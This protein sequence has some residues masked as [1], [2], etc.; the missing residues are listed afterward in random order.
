[1]PLNKL[2][3]GDGINADIDETSNSDNAAAALVN[4]YRDRSG[5][6][7]TIIG[8]E[9]YT[10]LGTGEDVWV[11]KSQHHDLKIFMSAGRVFKQ[12]TLAGTVTELTGTVVDSLPELVGIALDITAIPSFAEDGFK[13]FFAANSAINVIDPSSDVVTQLAGNAPTSVTSLAFIQGYLLA[14][15]TIAGDLLDGFTHHSDDGPWGDDVPTGVYSTW[16]SYAND[17]NPDPIQSMVIAFDRIYN[18]GTQSME[19]TFIDGTV[20]ISPDKNSSQP[21]GTPAPNSVAFDKESVYFL[22]E[23]AG[24]FKVVKLINGG[25][26]K[27]I[28]IAISAKINAMDSV[29]DARGH[30]MA[31]RGQNFYVLHFPSANIEIA[32]Q[33]YPEIT[34]AYHLQTEQWTIFADW[35]ATHGQFTAYGGVSFM[36]CGDWGVKLQG[37]DDGKVYKLIEN[38]TPDADADAPLLTHRWRDDGSEQ[39]KLPRIVSLGKLGDYNTIRYT[40]QIGQYYTRQHEIIYTDTSDA[41][42]T[43]RA[44]IRTGRISFGT[45][46]LKRGGRDGYKYDIKRGSG[47]FVLNGIWE[48]STGV[49]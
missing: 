15:G 17:A 11:Y 26:P 40:R 41:G 44:L 16:E 36:N 45:R 31:F 38:G 20:P 14:N 5:A 28:D 1:M 49:R 48:D 30:L 18:I 27:I 4:V 23:M 6:Y 2:P 13:I 39:W 37:G 46:N 22:T 32:N 9:V 24:D 25:T 43:F 42:N 21:I 12:T 10:D 35:D 47:E 8:R 7:R 29:A 19:V 3:I 33:N 34:L